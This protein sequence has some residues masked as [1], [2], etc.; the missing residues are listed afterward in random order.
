MI[1]AS[2]LDMV[3]DILQESKNKQFLASDWF[4]GKLGGEKCSKNHR[5]HMGSSLQGEAKGLRLAAQMIC[6]HFHT[7]HTH[8]GDVSALVCDDCGKTLDVS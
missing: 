2:N 4:S 1:T 5:M 3:D 7:S 8:C 6:F